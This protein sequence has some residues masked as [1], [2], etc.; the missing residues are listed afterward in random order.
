MTL[1]GVGSYY[2][3]LMVE[4]K[5]NDYQLYRGNNLVQ[6][7]Y[8]HNQNNKGSF[9]GG[10]PTEPPPNQERVIITHTGGT[11]VISN[12]VKPPKVKAM[13]EPLP[14]NEGQPGQPLRFSQQ[15]PA[16]PVYK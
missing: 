13:P 11:E 15:P 10:A 6:A 12:V 14:T 1:C 3:S 5:S 7:I 4:K 16:N 8:E 2:L 9:G